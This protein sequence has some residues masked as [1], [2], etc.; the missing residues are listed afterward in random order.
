[1]PHIKLFIGAEDESYLE[2]VKSAEG[3]LFFSILNEDYECER[4]IVIE[5]DDVKLLINEIKRL[6]K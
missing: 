6:Y 1:M 4:F 3:N 2:I 5:Q